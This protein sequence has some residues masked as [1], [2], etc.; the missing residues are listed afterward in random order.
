MDH[1]EK[2]TF[3]SLASKGIILIHGE[4]N[5]EMVYRVRDGLLMMQSAGIRQLAVNISSGGGHVGAGLDIYDMI[6]LAPVEKRIGTVSCFARSM[7]AIILQACE[8]RICARHASVLIHYVSTS[9]ISLDT[10]KD[11]KRLA[12]AIAVGERDQQALDRILALRTK[13]SVREIRRACA[14]DTDMNA[15]EALSFGLIDEII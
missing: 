12:H 9:S 13:K 6:R 11:K 5:G 2:E 8:H 4:V 3:F 14:K 15:E 10:M 7:G 1:N